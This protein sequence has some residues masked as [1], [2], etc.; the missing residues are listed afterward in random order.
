[1]HIL[2]IRNQSHLDPTPG[3]R[4]EDCVLG[5]PTLLCLSILSA[6]FLE[7]SQ[8]SAS[9]YEIKE[10]GRKLKKDLQEVPGVLVG[11]GLGE[12]EICPQ[13]P[14]WGLHFLQSEQD[15]Y[16]E[17]KRL[18]CPLEMKAVSLV[19]TMTAVTLPCPWVNS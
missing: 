19:L 18:V 10:V 5:D 12:N 9:F 17:R 14:V 3:S 13:A 2:K 16:E 8:Q 4:L 1:M 6:S 15:F 11:A 7:H